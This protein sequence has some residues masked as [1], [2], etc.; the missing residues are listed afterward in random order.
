MRNPII[1][2]LNEKGTKLILSF[3]K[4]FS[5]VYETKFFRLEN[6]IK[7]KKKFSSIFLHSVSFSKNLL[8]LVDLKGGFFF[9]NFQIKK[10]VFSLQNPEFSSI[11]RFFFFN[12]KFFLIQ[13]NQIFPIIIN[14]EFLN[15][16]FFN[17]FSGFNS[18]FK[19]KNKKGCFHLKSSSKNFFLKNQ[20]KK[21]T[22]CNKFFFDLFN[23]FIWEELSPNFFICWDLSSKR[24]LYESILFNIEKFSFFWVKKKTKQNLYKKTWLKKINFKKKNKFSGISNFNLED[25]L[26]SDFL[27]FIKRFISLTVSSNSQKSFFSWSPFFFSILKTCQNCCGVEFWEKNHQENWEG[28]SPSYQE[29]DFSS[30][31][32]AKK[33]FFFLKFFQKQKRIFL[34]KERLIIVNF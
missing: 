18:F 21:K 8:L 24:K 12:H 30:H 15:Q 32:K 14:L 1:F 5:L 17:N 34:N 7:T 11:P 19:T 29:V 33:K 2:K 25:K 4:N 22:Y 10:I 9:Y 23:L 13:K 27:N 28:V 31:T 3:E 16:N 6:I 20:I 26:F